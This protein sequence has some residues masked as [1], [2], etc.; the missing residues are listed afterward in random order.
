MIL[1]DIADIVGMKQSNTSQH[2]A[3]L[4]KARV[5]APRREGNMIFYSLANPHVAEACDMVENFV[6][7]HLKNEQKLARKM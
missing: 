7:E 4:R 1:N 5:I 3:V 2:L 6:A